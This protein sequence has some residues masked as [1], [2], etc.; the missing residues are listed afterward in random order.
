MKIIYLN[1]NYGKNDFNGII[2]FVK[3][4][5]D[6]DVF[7]FQEA[8]NEIGLKL[9]SIL[10]NYNKSFIN[11][12][13]EG[14]GSF[15]LK[16]YLNKKYQNFSFEVFEDNFE[17]TAPFILLKIVDENSNWNI[18]NFH[19]SPQP[20]DKLDNEIRINATKKIISIMSKTSGAKIIGGDFNLL[21]NTRSIEAFE[22]F[23][24][25]NLIKDF[26]I[27]TTRNENAWKL[28]DNKQLFADYIFVS[29]ETDI[30]KFEVIENKIS[31]HLPMM[32]EL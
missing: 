1:L 7:C 13:I 8:K 30:K 29:K 4:N 31:D 23:G 15:N 18:L 28:Y 27:K 22:N 16:T 5:L 25:K 19:G 14:F 11:K 12:E 26:K 9:D 17:N 10:E 24:Y 20:G 3:N 6:F 32:L 21:P 2:E